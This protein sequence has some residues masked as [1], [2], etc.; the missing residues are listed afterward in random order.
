MKNRIKFWLL[1][2]IVSIASFKPQTIHALTGGPS[3]PEYVQFEPFDAT[4]LVGLNTGNFTYTVPILNVPGVGGSFPIA[5][6]YH[7]GIQHGQEATWVGLGWTLNPG[8]INRTMRGYPD[9]YYDAFV[10]SDI[11][12]KEESG[13][14]L[15]IG[16]GW[17][18]F[19]A[20]IS[21]DSYTGT[22][23]FVG[24]LSISQ[25]ISS[26]TGGTLNNI[27]DLSIYT[28]VNSSGDV[29]FDVAA[30][31]GYSKYG[32][33]A[34]LEGK[35]GTSGQTA[36]AKFNAAKASLGYSW[37]S[38]GSGSYF[39]IAGNRTALS[40][41]SIKATEAMV[42]SS[43]YESSM[44]IPI[45]MFWI[46][47]ANY[48]WSWEIDSKFNE[49]QYG[50]LYQGG[51]AVFEDPNTG[52]C[53]HTR[54]PIVEDRGRRFERQMNDN[55]LF[56]S[57]DIY[58]CNAQGINGSFMPIAHN[59]VEYWDN[60]DD[61]DKGLYLASESPFTPI[62][63]ENYLVVSND[64]SDG[65]PN[66]ES[67]I[68]FRFLNDIGKN[69]IG[70][71]GA[72][73]IEGYANIHD[74]GCKRNYGSKIINPIIDKKSGL[75]KGFEIIDADGKIYEFKK[76]L[77]NYLQCNY[78]TNAHI[79][80]GDQFSKFISISP[81][82]YAWILTAIKSPD[83]VDV[84]NDGP[85]D[86][87]YGFWAKLDY[88]GNTPEE[89][90]YYFRWQ[91]PYKGNRRTDTEK[92]EA[93]MG[94]K[95]VA[96]LKSIETATHE[97]VFE[98]TERLDGEGSE[99]NLTLDQFADG[100]SN[101]SIPVNYKRYQKVN[102]DGYYE[103]T[104]TWNMELPE[105]LWPLFEAKSDM[106]IARVYFDVD[107]YQPQG[108][109]YLNQ[110]YSKEIYGY[111]TNAQLTSKGR[112][113]I[114]GSVKF[115]SDKKISQNQ[116]ITLEHEIDAQGTIY[117]KTLIQQVL[118][119]DDI[120]KNLKKLSRIKLYKKN[121]TSEKSVINSIIFNYD[122]SLCKNTP[123]SH[124]TFDDGGE[125]G[126]LTL[127][128]FQIVGKEGLALPPYIFRYQSGEGNPDF[129]GNENCDIWG[130]YN[131]DGLIEDKMTPQDRGDQ[132]GVAWNLTNIATPIGTELEINYERDRYY[133]VSGNRWT[134]VNYPIKD[135]NYE[136]IDIVSL[137]SKYVTVSEDDL[138][139]FRV[140]SKVL[141]LFEYVAHFWNAAYDHGTTDPNNPLTFGVGIYNVMEINDEQNWLIMEDKFPGDSFMKGSNPYNEYPSFPWQ[142]L[143]VP[144]RF[145]IDF[146][147][148]YGI[149][150]YLKPTKI[151]LLNDNLEFLGGDVRVKSI[152]SRNSMGNHFI[153]EYNY[154][155]YF[156]NEQISK[157]AGRI[158][159]S[160][161]TVT[162]AGNLNFSPWS[163]MWLF[164]S[165]GCP[166]PFPGHS[167]IVDEYS[168]DYNA[169]APGVIYGHVTVK[170]V[171]ASKRQSTNGMM[172]FDFCIPDDMDLYI[173]DYTS[174]KDLVIDDYSSMFGQ[175]QSISFY[176]DDKD[177]PVKKDIFTYDFGVNIDN[178]KSDYQ[179]I[180]GKP[181]G[182]IAQKNGFFPKH[183]I[184]SDP[185]DRYSVTYKMHNLYQVS[186]TTQTDKVSS[187]V[188]NIAFDAHSGAPLITETVQ[189]V[190][191][192]E[193]PRYDKKIT[194]I[195]PAYWEYDGLKDKNMLTQVF[196]TTTYEGSINNT[197][198]KAS[199]IITWNNNLSSDNTQWYKHETYQWK[200]DE[201]TPGNNFVADYKNHLD[202]WVKTDYVY[203][204]DNHGRVIEE[205]NADDVPVR[206]EKE[207]KW[208][209]SV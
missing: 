15:Y 194:E 22:I 130:M 48:S 131:P 203:K 85:T 138:A 50:Y 27:I 61:K 103:L 30:S 183:D 180:N 111:Y 76:P 146:K 47:I 202:Q 1:L 198:A 184:E 175:L 41:T 195:I 172:V 3:M 148:W 106:N 54:D 98:L 206:D 197:N 125:K 160:P 159:R 133:G 178:V 39:S 33:G 83:Y 100:V 56:S 26:Y 179:D 169:P 167:R 62:N 105:R 25:L 174:E 20:S 173:A 44:T 126:K 37:S 165:P 31:V 143:D 78:T 113:K 117:S 204:Y 53:T 128:S 196:Q 136:E 64:E 65:S 189:E 13:W 147:D 77:Y 191:E 140:G 79:G 80:L 182:L 67:N 154:S 155:D 208:T 96:Y 123:N 149:D 42:Q 34:A 28:G 104:L 68:Q 152:H 88:Q 82:A 19:G 74:D 161:S 21:Y 108:Y 142:I 59:E 17:G 127:K 134:G 205:R 57:Q 168:E 141:M 153:T 81:Y 87:D 114:T 188:S 156:Q 163:N 166:S 14:G 190:P 23:G 45:K 99:F 11:Y 51:P 150:C 40:P 124:A 71:D 93:G 95:D 120:L 90:S 5:L 118:T 110:D 7:G 107:V 171:D 176:N 201:A 24:I 38:N 49:W 4:D 187:K 145:G 86:D 164:R 8:A 75:L 209:F 170:N 9:D 119:G 102:I 139:K 162:N 101:I 60:A 52:N 115:V 16:G 69:A 36:G 112:V 97:A 12:S 84:L 200:G 132:I 121:T 2:T 46:S 63:D 43:E 72:S 35:M 144:Y 70:K 109:V 177:E 137:Y 199:S 10:Y 151:V 116:I 207:I 58:I 94:V 89:E 135:E 73:F 181:P 55:W 122:Y 157:T 6:S 32:I 193:A 192:G 66:R 129:G 186:V 29:S 18:P 158:Y 92:Y 185:E 91:A